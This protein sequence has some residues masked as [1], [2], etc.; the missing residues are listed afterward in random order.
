[1]INPKVP[2]KLGWVVE[3]DAL[4]AVNVP[5]IDVGSKTTLNDAERVVVLVVHEKDGDIRTDRKTKT[6]GRI[7]EIIKDD[8]LLLLTKKNV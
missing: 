5:C 8:S 7:S 2:A 1:L 3:S 4:R 6:L